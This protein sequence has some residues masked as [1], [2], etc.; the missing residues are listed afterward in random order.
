M[1]LKMLNFEW[2]FFSS[3]KW[4]LNCN[5]DLIKI[6]TLVCAYRKWHW[7]NEMRQ[8]IDQ[9]T[10]ILKEEFIINHINTLPSLKR[11]AISV[12]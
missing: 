1:T 10:V 11:I 5:N 3:S 8:K 7:L 6:F 2:I 4:I 12:L 9:Y